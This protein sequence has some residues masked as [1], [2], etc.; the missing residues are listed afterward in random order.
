M[1]V[2]NEAYTKLIQM[3]GKV[4]LAF[5]SIVTNSTPLCRCC[6]PFCFRGSV[7]NTCGSSR[8]DISHMP[9]LSGGEGT[10]KQG[11]SQEAASFQF[12]LLCYYVETNPIWPDP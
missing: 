2:T 5:K 9:C 3:A 11:P 6:K 8:V 1:N 10:E 7:F 4:L 12:L